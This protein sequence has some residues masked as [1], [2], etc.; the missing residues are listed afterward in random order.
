MSSAVSVE[1]YSGQKPLSTAPAV[2]PFNREAYLARVDG[3]A[4]F[5]RELIDLFLSESPEIMV[6]ISRAIQT[7]DATALRLAAHTMRG[8]AANFS[9]QPTQDIAHRLEHLGRTG[10]FSGTQELYVTLVE[11]VTRLRSALIALSA[12]LA[13]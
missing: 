11:V 12:D 9:A 1:V 2:A 8:T 6:T 13:S 7:G 3:D 10:E 4:A 5:A